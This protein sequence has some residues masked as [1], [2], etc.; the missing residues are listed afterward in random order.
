MIS[1]YSALGT[2]STFDGV[3]HVII[4]LI[5]ASA[6]L[7]AFSVFFFK[8]EIRLFLNR[9]RPIKIFM[10][11]GVNMGA[12]V[13]M[14]RKSKL[15]K[16]EEPTTD[17]RQC[18][19]IGNHSLIIIGYKR[20]MAG[21]SDIVNAARTAKI[22]VIVYAKEQLEETDKSLLNSY[23]WHS[24]CNFPLKLMNDVFTILSTFPKMK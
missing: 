10:A 3:V 9:R 20:Q 12:E 18:D 15:F 16:I 13:E 21:L 22:P 6:F 7:A 17:H 24:V 1:I 4:G 23:S 5:V 14:L 19:G 2:I 8:K 11:D